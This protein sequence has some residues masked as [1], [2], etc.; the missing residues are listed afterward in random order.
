MT[1]R[2][3]ALAALAAL[4]L[5]ACQR[6]AEDSNIAIDNVINAAEA[7]DADVALPPSASDGAALGS[8][9]APLAN[10]ATPLPTSIPVQFHGR[11]GINRLDCTSTRGD[12]KGLMTIAATRLTFYESSG[13]LGAV[14]GATPNSFDAEYAF[15]GEGQTWERVERFKLVDDRLQRRTNAAPGQEPPVNLTYERCG[16]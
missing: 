3:F 16:S 13:S 5:A 10:E 11:W 2:N 9:T 15:T 12:A 1:Q 7:A 6:P 14:L 4:A 8:P